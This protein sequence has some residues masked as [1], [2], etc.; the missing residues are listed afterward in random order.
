MSG[1]ATTPAR[2]TLA[3]LSTLAAPTAA[4]HTG[5]SAVTLA[6][7]EHAELIEHPAAPQ[8]D[9]PISD[10]A[11]AEPAP[12]APV[13][14]G[15]ALEGLQ[16]LR[17]EIAERRAECF[18]SLAVTALLESTGLRDIDARERFGYPDLFALGEDVLPSIPLPPSGRPSAT[19]GHAPFHELLW[20]FAKRYSVGLAYMVPAS[21]Q[22][23]CFVVFGYSLW[24]SG[25]FT[26]NQATVVALATLL[27]LA[28]TAPFVQT[29][30]RRGAYYRQYN[31][32]FLM[33]R[34]IE[35]IGGA[36]ILFAL[37]GVGVAASLWHA[38]GGGDGLLL[39]GY[40]TLLSLFWLALAGIDMCRLRWLVSP[41]TVAAVALVALLHE[42]AGMPLVYAQWA[43]LAAV[44]AALNGVTAWRLRRWAKRTPPALRHVPL[45]QL[46][47][48]LAR[49]LP[50]LLYGLLYYA[51]LFTDR[52]V[53]WTAGPLPGGRAIGFRGDYEAGLDWALLVL[54]LSTSVFEQTIRSFGERLLPVA[55]AT[56]ASDDAGFAR[57]FRKLYLQ[58]AA[59]LFVAG[60][61]S[62]ALVYGALAFTARLQG[63]DAVFAHPVVQR[64]FLFGGT[65][66]L[67]F[68]AG[69]FYAIF[70]QSLSRQAMVVRWLLA[71]LCI[72]AAVGLVASRAFG[73]EWAVLGLIAGAAYFAT[74]CAIFSV[75]T[76]RH[77]PYHLAA[78]LA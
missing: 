39:F 6:S 40:G 29:I 30:A 32:A 56:R 43:G 72:D 37:P 19:T 53:A 50:V 33:R 57:A 78:T 16:P 1:D 55:A 62:L 8:L 25:G 15:G 73:Y 17:A 66:Y 3:P 76:L 5:G 74:C 75:R 13:S 21:A 58:Q 42:L 59:L 22:I 41:V 26:S 2:Q 52:I 27:S 9:P 51:L 12:T 67:F 4:R 18:D 36:G 34:E 23:L 44:W 49:T 54:L 20:R 61:V 77:G 63:G 71:G 47:V 35:R 11:A 70:L 48:L 65:G 45:L 7:G 14:P 38:S 60:V 24:A 46:R 31:N 69:L 64:V 28:L 10:A 68:A